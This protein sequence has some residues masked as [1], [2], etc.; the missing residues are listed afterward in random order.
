MKNK[1]AKNNNWKFPKKVFICFLLIMLIFIGQ[2]GYLSL[3]KN[4]YGINMK[5]FSANRNTVKTIL[6]SKRGTIYDKD[7]N[8][9]ASNVTSY[10]VIAYLNEKITGNSK[11]QKHVTDVHKTAEA[12]SPIINMEVESIE[13][14]LNEGIANN[15]WQVEL[16]PGGRNI[17]ELKKEQI[18]KLGLPG[19]DFVESIKR[20]YPNGDFAS[21]I[22]GYV[23][24]YEEPVFENGIEKIQY[25][26]IGEMGIEAKYNENLTGK[27]GSITYQKDL[28]GYKIP[29]TPE[30]LVPAQDGN[31]IYLT[32]DSSIQR[33]VEAAVK[34]VVEEANPEWMTITVMDAKTGDIL[35]TTAA[36]SFDPNIKDIKS[37]E[38]P[39]ITTT[40]E[41]GSTMKIYTYMCAMETGQ[42]D[43]NATYES[44][45][46]KF[47]D[48]EEV[49]D[50]NKYGW[51]YISYDKGFE[52]SSNVAVSTLLQTILNKNKYRECLEKYGFGQ[53]TGIELS[54]ESNGNISTFNY[55]IEVANASFGQGITIT[56]MQMLQGL[57]ILSND[58]KMLKP[59]I[60]EKIVNSNTNEVIY[61]KE[62]EETDQI[63]SKDTVEK[64]KKLMYNVVNS[65]DEIATGKYYNINGLNVIGKTGTA[66]IFDVQ[67][68]RYLDGDND[69]IFSFA[70]MYPYEDP[71]VIIYTTMKKP[72][73][74]AQW[75]MVRAA[76]LVMESVAKYK[77]IYN[78]TSNVVKVPTYKIENYVNKNINDIKGSLE[79]K[80]IDIITIGNGDTIVNQYPGP[81]STITEHEK[82]FLVTNNSDITMPNMSNWSLGNAKKFFELAN[83]SYMTEGYGYVKEQSIPEGT[84]LDKSVEIKI[85]LYDKYY[86]V[87]PE[88][89]ETQENPEQNNQEQENNQE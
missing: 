18:E 8:T 57:T 15:A 48:D 44:G 79:G 73:R 80:N 49:R 1:K 63:V 38:N 51:G 67:Q 55:P 50:W 65:D 77:G 17:T 88:Q 89:P 20:Y 5:D 46:I 14:L 68:N 25:N 82:L 24:R 16:G 2:L 29:D 13:K 85:T 56:A 66:Q 28:S 64:M 54:N 21:Y 3:S 75:P 62:K 43:G 42:Y 59:H 45:S 35:G 69:Y 34:D 37:Y 58:G 83:V 76:R 19:I 39:L 78:D 41:P 87:P 86:Y 47:S 31:D 53:K 70:G 23:R 74:D 10:T 26:L 52:Y 72:V 4:I 32:I 7:G 11:I 61:K 9:L 12:L 30:T 36:P 6:K 27:D 40:Y 71:E 81:N 33:F 60:V 22:I 84:L